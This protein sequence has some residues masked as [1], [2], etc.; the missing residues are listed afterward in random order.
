MLKFK[1]GK[2]NQ[3]ICQNICEKGMM[4]AENLV[5]VPF[6]CPFSRIR[7]CPKISKIH[8]LPHG[9]NEKFNVFLVFMDVCF[10]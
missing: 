4:H 5:L 2:R 3:L 1:V 6:H 9:K 8:L 7:H 10:K